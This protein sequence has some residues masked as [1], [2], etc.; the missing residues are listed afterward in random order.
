VSLVLPPDV[1]TRTR[2]RRPA[3]RGHWVDLDRSA[4]RHRYDRMAAFIPLFDW[5][6]FHPRDFRKMAAARLALANGDCVLEIG[7]GTGLNF[8]H[9]SA[10]VGPDGRVY[11]VDISPGMLARARDLCEQQRLGNVKLTEGDALDFQAPEPLDGVMFGLS[12]NTMPHHL[13]VLRH[14][15]SLLRPGGRLVIMDSKLPPGLGGRLVRPFSIWLMKRTMLGNPDIRPWEDLARLTDALQMEEF[16]FGSHYICR[17]I[18]PQDSP[19][20]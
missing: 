10:A 12:Y 19:R 5:A 7:C 8:P 2:F 13:A 1:G 16:V 11:G 9:L 20:A 4:I 6:F 14:A 18:K 15:W 17:G 3:T